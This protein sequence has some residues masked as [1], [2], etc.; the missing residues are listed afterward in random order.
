MNLV[1]KRVQNEQDGVYLENKI[2]MLKHYY[3]KVNFM[4]G[5][6]ILKNLN[7]L[8]M[9]LIMSIEYHLQDEYEFLISIFYNNEKKNIFFSLH[10]LLKC[11]NQLM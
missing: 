11:L 3:L 1:I 4:I 5:L 8:M 7:R 2:K 6:V 10:Q 9:L